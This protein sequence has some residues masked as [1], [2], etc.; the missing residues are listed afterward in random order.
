M[1]ELR[2]MSPA[3]GPYC[4][5]AAT[6]VYYLFAVARRKLSGF[7]LN[8]SV[9]VGLV[10]GVTSLAGEYRTFRSAVVATGMPDLPVLW[11]RQAIAR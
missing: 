7:A 3:T 8:V 6:G 4:L 5:L 10:L 9:I 2:I 11:L 1:Q